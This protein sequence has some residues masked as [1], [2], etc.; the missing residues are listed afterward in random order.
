VEDGWRQLV[1]A[2]AGS[3]YFMTPDWVLAS[4]EA[5][6]ARAAA[7]AVV[8]VWTGA[9]GR[10]E[11]LAPLLRARLR[12]HPRIPVPVDCWTVLGYDADAADHGIFPALPHRAGELRAWLR[13]RTRGRSVWLP[14]MDQESDRATLPPGC[15]RLAATPCPRLELT[16]GSRPGPAGL[17]RAERRLRDVGVG[18]R[19]V[20]PERMDGRTLDT[21][22]ALHARRQAAKGEPTEFTADRRALHLGLQR[23]AA[24]GR[25][26]A[27]LLAERDGVP[28]GAVYGFLWQDTFAYYNGGWEAEFGRLSL[29]AVLHLRAIS[30]V[31]GLGVRTYDFL[32]GAELYKYQRFGARDRIDGQWLRPR[33]PSALL[34][35]A[36]LHGAR[37]L[38][39]ARR[40]GAN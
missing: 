2:S 26:P 4:W 31:A 20:P 22:I 32:R 33:S 7:R 10:I 30:T 17:R 1:A 38:S 19:W 9:D 11:A 27:A 13:A 5:L 25:G 12:L 28:V 36:V 40:R 14:A 23:R 34:A 8:A 18:F 35:G 6:P 37:R 3:S 21:V 24:P 29:G 16:P 39:G 15:R